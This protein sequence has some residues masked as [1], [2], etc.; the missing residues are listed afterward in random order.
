[1]KL[2]LN[3]Q[4]ILCAVSPLMIAASGKSTLS[5]ID[6]ILIEAKHPDTCTFTAYDHEK[7]VR[8][9]IETKVVEEGSYIINAQK[10]ISIMRVM[11]GEEV[12]FT[13]DAQLCAIF[14]SGR[15]SHKMIA[16]KGEEFPELPLLHS[17]RG[18]S[19]TC[20]MLREMLTKTMYAMGVNDQ[21]PEL[22][23]CFFE[24]E[25]DKLLL[26][27]CN[28]FKLAKCKM[29]A[30]IKNNNKDG[31]DLRYRFIVPVKTVNELY[32]LITGDAE[33]EL[34]IYM[35][36]RHIIFHID[37]V[38]FFSR[39][40]DGTYIDYDRFIIQQHRIKATLNRDALLAA[41][42]RAALITEERVAG[43]VRSH[44]KLQ[45]EGNV[46][47]VMASSAAGSTYDEI[48]M[49]HEGSDLLIAFNNRFL[50]DS[51]R[52]CEAET[53]RLSMSASTL[54]VNI[55]PVEGGAENCEDIFMV[56][57]VRLKE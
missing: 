16:L 2:I 49:E 36:R 26:V 29:V 56:L 38:V 28:S 34:T 54:P 37:D 48:E 19:L 3:R 33:K 9:T 51:V 40:I 10:F 46:L 45:L 4:Q 27:S 22:N 17:E 50:I 31:S 44:V 21:R 15:S 7:G 14:E 53:I 43:S 39:L 24:V 35:T 41:L 18:F 52:A 12:T 13:V 6:G 25:S 57:P 1:M 20:G 11:D 23:G 47:K 8:T 30:D 5:A 42:D 55:E 32:K